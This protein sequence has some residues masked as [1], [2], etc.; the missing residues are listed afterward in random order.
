[1]IDDSSIWRLRIIIH[2]RMVPYLASL[3]GIYHRLIQKYALAYIR[4]NI[5]TFIITE[6]DSNAKVE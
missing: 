1:M 4:E 6:G 3:K 2:E 5:T